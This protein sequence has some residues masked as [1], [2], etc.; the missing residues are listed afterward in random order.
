MLR[1]KLDN[2]VGVRLARFSRMLLERT[3]KHDDQR[4]HGVNGLP[5]RCHMESKYRNLCGPYFGRRAGLVARCAFDEAP[6]HHLACQPKQWRLYNYVQF[7]PLPVPS[8][9]KRSAQMNC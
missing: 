6:V 9:P 2:I 5:L 7:P 8:L 4:S 3:I 1:I